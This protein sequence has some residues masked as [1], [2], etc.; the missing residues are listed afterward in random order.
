MNR[1][2]KVAFIQVEKDGSLARSSEFM[3]AFRNMKIIVKT[4]GGDA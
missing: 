3:R 4:T 2:N 1:D